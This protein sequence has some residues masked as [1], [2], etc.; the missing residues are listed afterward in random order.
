MSIYVHIKPGT[1]RYDIAPLKQALNKAKF[2]KSYTYTTAEDI[3]ASEVND[4]NR[5]AIEL[6]DENPYTD[7]IDIKLNTTYINPDSLASIKKTLTNYQIVEEVI[8][9]SPEIA[10]SVDKS[11]TKIML[12]VIAI[13]TLLLVISIALINNTVSLSIYSRRF[14]IHTMKL[15]G[16]TRGYIRRPFVRAATMAGL[17]AGLIASAIVCGTYYYLLSSWTD[18]VALVSWTDIITID[19]TLILFSIIVCATTAWCA[20]NRYLN[21]N[22]DKLF[23]K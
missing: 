5:H 20:A 13:A 9:P 19:T 21:K 16:A 15:V 8:L 2:A 1:E 7:E 12:T 11:L 14:I 23:M 22:Y 3:L 17:I 10:G 6:L 18:T 4:E